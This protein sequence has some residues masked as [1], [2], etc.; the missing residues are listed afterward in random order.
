MAKKEWKFYCSECKGLAFRR[1]DM[2]SPNM[3]ECP[4]CADIFYANICHSC[5]AVVNSQFCERCKSCDWGICKEC[6]ACSPDCPTLNQF[7][8]AYEE[9]E[10]SFFDPEVEFL[11]DKRIQAEQ[12][13]QEKREEDDEQ[14]LA[15]QEAMAQQDEDLQEG[16]DYAENCLSDD[17]WL[18]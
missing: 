15:L 17:E 16:L 11:E 4:Q 12:D 2:D 14:A 10:D 6:G 8:D 9:H 7:G 13:A 3:Y 5:K 1:E 18:G